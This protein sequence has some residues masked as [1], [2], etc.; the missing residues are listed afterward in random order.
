MK[1]RLLF[2][3]HAFLS[4][5]FLLGFASMLNGFRFESLRVRDDT[6]PELGPPVYRLVTAGF[7]PAAVDFLWIRS[8]QEIGGE[9]EPAP[10]ASPDAARERLIHLY[11]EIHSMDPNFYETYEQGA[12]YFALIRND[13]APALEI[14]DRGIAAH[15][16]GLAPRAFWTHPVSL[17]L[18]RGYVNAFLREDFEAAKQ[19]YLNASRVPDAPEYLRS[20]R[21]WLLEEGGARKLARKVLKILSDQSEDP[22]LKQKYREALERDGQ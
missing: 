9:K 15:R 7:W 6:G 19:D 11:R 1:W 13:P 8:L 14:L 22:V 10:G 2:H 12:V 20:M 21:D 16:S 18:L 5:V 4:F 3:H 17:Y